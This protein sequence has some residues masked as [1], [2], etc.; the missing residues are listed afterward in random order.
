MVLPLLLPLRCH[1]ERSER[2]QHRSGLLCGIQ[3]FQPRI[4][5]DC[6]DSGTEGLFSTSTSLQYSD[7]DTLLCM[8]FDRQVIEAKLALE[9]IASADMPSIAWDALEEGLDGTATRRLAAL[10]H[11]T[12]FEVAEVLPRAMQE[13]GLSK[14]PA[15]EAASR[16]AKQIAQKILLSG[17]NP[18]KHV[19]DFES[20][21]IR[22]NY[23]LEISHLG[24]LYDDVYI[25]Q[26]MG[27]SDAEIQE[28]VTSILS[29]FVRS[30]ELPRASCPP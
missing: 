10:D 19:R 12:Y 26:M 29:N 23:A 2:P 25:A 14:I 17:E 9:L 11:P 5:F 16:M 28:W 6:S 8:S 7:C 22:A 21:W 24:T 20:I 13:L 18:L 4:D 27:R 15:G 3:A 1:L 30:P